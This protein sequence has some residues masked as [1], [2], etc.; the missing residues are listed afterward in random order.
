MNGRRH[1]FKG[2]P[3][4][5]THTDASRMLATM[6]RTKSAAEILAA[7]GDKVWTR[8][9][10]FIWTHTS[11]LDGGGGCGMCVCGIDT[12]CN[13]HQDLCVPGGCDRG[14]GDARGGDEGLA[15]NAINEPRLRLL[16]KHIHRLCKQRRVD[17]NRSSQR[18][19]CCTRM[20]NHTSRYWTLSGESFLASGVD[21]PIGHT[22]GVFSVSV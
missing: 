14:L 2:F 13:S 15:A 4:Q 8:N 16:Y 7:V 5:F 18:Q 11:S 12:V 20:T 9:S 10:L 22:S 19:T 17:S 1:T 21:S 3:I 6:H